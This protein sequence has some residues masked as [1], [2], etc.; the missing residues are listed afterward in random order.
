M[1]RRLTTAMALGLAMTIAVSAQAAGYT[2]TKVQ[3]EHR[4]QTIPLHIWYP[5]ESTDAEITL[6]NNAVF[7][8]HQ[9]R[10][11]ADPLPGAYPLVI[12]SHGSGGN[13]LN[14]GWIASYLADQ[15]MIVAATNHPGSTS[16]DSTQL[17]T[18][19][20]WQRPEDISAILDHFEKTKVAG[21]SPDMGKVGAVGFSLGGY[22]V[23]AAAGARVSKQSY[24][25]YCTAN[26]SMFDCAWFADGGV[27]LNTAD[28]ARFNQSNLDP[29]LTA[30][31]SIDPALAQ[32]YTSESLNAV[33]I[34][35]AIV[36]LG[37]RETIPAPLDGTKLMP[38]LNEGA[39]TYVEGAH[40]FSF[41]GTC[42]P[43]GQKILDGSNE[44]PL[45][46]SVSAR[47]RSDIHD[48]IK[49]YV[50]NFLKSSF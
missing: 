18:L 26:A 22:T 1:T 2:T 40:H 32:A 27:D 8:G 21:L 36:N 35:V 11:D 50:S 41:L 30:V 5:S 6:G 15:G 33:D 9:V 48:E 10:P 17:E 38:H 39:L 45:C 49:T 28:Q 23:L 42:T 19:K 20:V 46:V 37:G 44:G 34:P 14:I 31:V 29:R 43:I 16:G 24:V 3:A 4:D 12:L 47:A 7:N 13:A 25:E